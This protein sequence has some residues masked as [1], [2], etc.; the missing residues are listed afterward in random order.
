MP[1]ALRVERD[2]KFWISVANHPDVKSGMLG[3]SDEQ[4]ASFV[5]S[6]RV[7]PLANEF[8]GFLFAS[9]DGL[10]RVYDL[11]ALFRPE[12]WG[13]PVHGALCE[14]LGGVFQSAH[15]VT[16]QQVASN[17]RSRPPLSFGFR[18][19]GPFEPSDFGLSRTWV[20]TRFAWLASLAYRRA[21][22]CL[23]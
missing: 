9:L 8:G 21:S 2:P 11:H 19:A 13:K 6:D 7:L 18:P 20:L 5:A 23:Q 16:V 10:G 4:L 17:P 14:A 3:L 1:V 15:L 22:S 12:G